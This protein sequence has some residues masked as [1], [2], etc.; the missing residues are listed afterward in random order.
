[1][2]EPLKGV[3]VATITPMNHDFGLDE[4][5]CRTYF[6]FLADHGPQAVFI[7]GSTGEGPALSND[8]R[9][10]LAELAVAELHGKVQV[11]AH[12]GHIN[13]ADTVALVRHAREAGADGAAVITPWYY[14][15]DEDSLYAYYRT[16]AES[17]PDF[18]VYLYNLPSYARNVIT[19]SLIARLA[20]DVPNI[21]GLKDSTG[22]FAALQANMAAT[23]RPFTVLSGSDAFALAGLA[24]GTVGFVSGNSSA[25]PEVFV[26]LWNAFQRGDLAAARRYQQLIHRI[27]AALK[28]GGNLAYFKTALALRGIPAGPVRPP[29][30]NLSESEVTELRKSLQPLSREY[31]DLGFPQY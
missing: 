12:A 7:A 20:A 25:F 8:E 5:A 30:P 28:D 24:L 29:R 15:L 23:D 21:A 18:P 11:I 1:M 31:S 22:D 6:R 4:A 13:T 17:V 10:R 9:F 14:A 27:R 3:V 2:P 16:V 26:G 19:P